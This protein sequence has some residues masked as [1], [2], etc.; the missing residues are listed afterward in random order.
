[1]T[2]LKNNLR[3]LSHSSRHVTIVIGIVLIGL[4]G[5][6]TLMSGIILYNW[7]IEDWNNDINNLSL[8]MAENLAQSMVSAELVLDGITE[9]AN[10]VA[11]D[12][13]APASQ[14]EQA[15]RMMHDKIT[16]VP[17][18]SGAALISAAGS[19]KVLTHP[20][21]SNGISIEDRDYYQY[22]LT[23]NSTATFFSQPAR[24]RVDQAWTFYLTRRLNDSRGQMRGIALVAISCDF[25][26]NFF[27]RVS[28]EKH[29]SIALTSSS[30]KLLAS[31]PATDAI[32]ERLH[33]SSGPD[34]SDEKP[35]I[36]TT[37]LVRNTP[38]HVEV[39]VTEQGFKDDW[40]RAMHLIGGLAAASMM[41]LLIAFYIM[42]AILKRRESDARRAIL[43]QEQADQANQAKSRFLAIMSHE[44]RTPM[45]GILGMSELLLDSPLA[46]PQHA[47]A[48]QIHDGSR[49]LMSI[50]N[51]ILDFSKI[52]AGRMDSEIINFSPSQLL[53]DVIDLHRVTAEKKNLAIHTDIP[54]DVIDSLAGD[55]LHL[56]QV[57]GN[58]LSNAIKFTA[59]G[60]IS[61]R[62]QTLPHPTAA[63]QINLRYAVTD[64][65]IGIDKTQQEGLFEA[66]I[67]ADSSISRNY[68]GTGL[69][70]SICKRLVEL[71]Q[72]SIS[73]E[74][75]Q[76]SGATF[77]F[78]VPCRIAPALNATTPALPTPAT[79]NTDGQNAST[80]QPSD[81]RV[82]IAEDTEINL[83]LARMLLSKKGYQVGVAENGRQA[84]NALTREHYDLVLMDCMMP[85]IDGF[86]ATRLWRE[87][88][89]ANGSQRIPV[90]AL[91]ASAIE[92]DRDRCLAAGMDDY[93]AKP[94]SASA[95][96]S[97]VERWL[98]PRP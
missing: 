58:L 70:L 8:V 11:L 78:E 47:Y 13:K 31:W 21:P 16:G 9:I 12:G 68:G 62:L 65:G 49:E 42:A 46:Q 36:S 72:G 20:T 25:F 1:M 29:V 67:Q 15:T 6:A 79:S 14:V 39:S 33:Q 64:T 18:I 3:Q 23:H 84:L 24:N 30:N 97:I 57:L 4:L 37:R 17:Q 96:L 89:A 94:F 51:E 87:Q 38:L 52:E 26:N 48:R 54:A 91:T 74:S 60:S 90:I 69:G 61:M 40:L 34:A 93:L 86:E 7:A 76:G 80:F 10:T 59:A 35:K 45:N 83:Q 19:V 32:G 77:S 53:R 75:D 27:K 82:L 98:K 22:H 2:A 28:V 85:L 56:R 88:E 92:G 81:W 44:I 66:F 50:I 71:M 41:A 43:L 5:S 55:A 63:D 73:C 95:F